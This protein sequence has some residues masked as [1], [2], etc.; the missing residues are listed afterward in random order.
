MYRRS[1]KW[2]DLHLD[3]GEFADNGGFLEEDNASEVCLHSKE[4]VGIRPGL[5][6]GS[7][8]WQR[9]RASTVDYGHVE[10]DHRPEPRSEYFPAS[11]EPNLWQSW[12][13]LVAVCTRVVNTKRHGGDFN[14]QSDE[15]LLCRGDDDG[16]NVLDWPSRLKAD[17]YETSG[18]DDDDDDEGSIKGS[19]FPEMHSPTTFPPGGKGDDVSTDASTASPATQ[20]ATSPSPFA[21]RFRRSGAVDFD[22]SEFS[23]ALGMPDSLPQLNEGPG[24]RISSSRKVTPGVPAGVLANDPRRLDVENISQQSHSRELSEHGSEIF[25]QPQLSASQQPQLGFFQKIMAT[26][27]P[28]N[29]R[30]GS[31]QPPEREPQ[32]PHQ[33]ARP[34]EPDPEGD[35]LHDHAH[36]DVSFGL[37]TFGQGRDPPRTPRRQSSS[38]T[39]D[40][41]RDQDE[42]PMHHS[43]HLQHG[44]SHSASPR[45]MQASSSGGSQRPYD[46]QTGQLDISTED[47]GPYWQQVGARRNPD[48]YSSQSLT[49]RA[50]Q[51]FP[52][53]NWSAAESYRPDPS[54]WNGAGA[55][56]RGYFEDDSFRSERSVL[57][58]AEPFRR[59]AGPGSSS[60][61]PFAASSGPFAATSSSTFS[62]SSYPYTNTPPSAANGSD[63]GWR[64]SGG[65]NFSNAL[66]QRHGRETE[67]AHARNTRNRS[68][69]PL[70]EGER[71]ELSRSGRSPWRDLDFDHTSNNNYMNYNYSINS[72]RPDANNFM[73]PA[74]SQ[75][76]FAASSFRSETN[77]SFDKPFVPEM[78]YR[79][80]RTDDMY[81][82]SSTKEVSTGSS[83][84]RGTYQSGLLSPRKLR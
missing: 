84:K 80:Q 30:S 49:E 34:A 55:H 24:S 14:L 20:T 36:G 15:I 64:H 66:V 45:L 33:E 71:G 38:N 73:P 68:M 79:G 63:M 31:K 29:S 51:R 74:A 27:S 40:A 56:R 83:Y 52:T 43:P 60:S 17:T 32:P 46:W 16:N 6:E 23:D 35:F 18:V 10:E 57:E 8:Q 22:N 67:M 69:P 82:T 37:G 81:G 48:M 11:G 42:A 61:G 9:P 62:T 78:S 76:Q 47:S 3:G 58:G 50:Q 26:L 70:L 59:G 1:V 65:G 75:G 2:E 41:Y 21:Q 4:R 7:D 12:S 13:N 25:T 44:Y 72:Y 77:R 5:R 28:A 39:W 54:A 53:A 19:L